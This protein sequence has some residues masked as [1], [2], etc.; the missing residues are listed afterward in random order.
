MNRK[1]NTKFMRL[2]KRAEVNDRSNLVE[3]FVDVGPL[4]TLLSSPDHQ[5]M[6]GRRGTGKTHALSYLAESFVRNAEPVAYVDLRTIGSSGGIYSDQSLSIAERSTRLLS[7]TLAAVHEELFSF[8]VNHAEE[9]DLSQTGPLL[10]DLVNDLTNVRVVGTVETEQSESSGSET[11]RGS[12]AR[13]VVST[14]ANPTLD[15]QR[16]SHSQQS[17]SDHTQ[18]RLAQSGTLQHSVHFGAVSRTLGELGK[19]VRPKRIW[20]L[21]DEWS[22]VPLDLQPYLA[23]FLRRSLMATRGVVVK[24]A[25]IEQRTRFQ[26]H[27]TE[28][29]YIG[30]ELGADAAADVNLDDFMVFDNDADR[31]VQF[32]R[33]LIYKHFIAVMDSDDESFVPDGPEQLIST[34]FT[35][36][37][38]FE[39]FV[40]ASEGVPRDAINILAIAATNALDNRLAMN[41]IRASA[42]NW[43]Q[44]DKE[45]AVRANES[46]TELLHWVIDEVI[47]HRRARG[48]LLRSTARHPIIDYLF[49]AR[50][51]HLLKRNVSAHD[52][53][54]VRYNVYK[55]D[56]GCY[57]DLINTTRNPQGLLAMGSENEAGEPD[58]FVDVPPDDYRSIRRAILN[59]DQ[60]DERHNG[61]RE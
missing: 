5:V 59:L 32:Y 22:S 14:Q 61:I 34:A 1:I 24:I 7:D 36:T 26:I 21:L 46:A 47:A 53:P 49:D 30:I 28:S 41:H 15:F 44:R 8:F 57:V 16:E 17:W 23:D 56:Y 40:R 43:Y 50:I 6:F 10:D 3:T 38:V 18:Q 2:S 4:F 48:F 45:A 11:Q 39:E 55:L 19:L 52:E 20:I 12:T 31:A 37:N 9:Y 58:F 42:K 60:F 33:Q 54:G 35:Q 29:N 25:A 13:T 27:L 51:L